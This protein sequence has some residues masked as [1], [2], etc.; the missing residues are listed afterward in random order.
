MTKKT[1]KLAVALALAGALLAGCSAAGPDR[2]SGTDPVAPSA[3]ATSAAPEIDKVAVTYVTAPLNVPSI[4]ERK[5]GIFADAFS[6]SGI[7]VTYSEL[8]TGPEQTAALASGDIQFLFGV[9][10]TSV[11]LAAA[12]GADIAVVDTYS[13]SPE[14]FQLVAGPNGPTSPAEL[15]GKTVAGPKGTILHQLLLA[16][17]ASGGLTAEDVTF[18]DMPIPDAHAALAGGSVDAALLAG[19]AAYQAVAEGNRTVTDGT[20]LVGAT[21]VVATS[22]TFAT[23]HPTVVSAFVAAHHAVL[24]Y[25]AERPDDALAMAADETGLSLGAVRGMFQQYDFSPTVT[26]ADVASLK[27]TEEFMLAN[28]MIEHR[29]DIPGLIL[30][31]G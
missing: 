12:N 14:A 5:A 7:D 21:I 6:A 15:K 23:E 10:A 1:P 20:G 19:P 22:R 30:A 25:M 28:G 8:T 9:G 24:D 3:A 16:Y 18:V 29:V 11:I 31:E 17:L 2:A 26:A 4:V 13:R 27:A